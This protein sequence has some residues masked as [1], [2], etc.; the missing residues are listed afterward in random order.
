MSS[1]VSP[2]QYLDDLKAFFDDPSNQQL[3]AEM[4]ADLPDV[5]QQWLGKA[6]LL[7]GAPFNNLLVDDR[8]LPPESIR[9]FYVDQ[10]WLDALVDGVFSVGVHSSRNT[11]LVQ[12]LTGAIR[13]A[14]EAEM[15][16]VRSRLRNVPPPSEVVVGG[17]MTGILMRSAAVAGWPGLVVKAYAQPGD[18]TPLPL[19]RM[20]RLAADV[21]ICLFSGVPGRVEVDEPPEGLH[22]GVEDDDLITLRGLGYNNHPA[23]VAIS[24]LTNIEAV[25]RQDGEGQNTRVLD[26]YGLQEKLG[27][28]L[29]AQGVRPPNAPA[30]LGAADF[31]I[32]MVDA[33]EQQAFENTSPPPAADS[34]L[35]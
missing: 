19:L 24:P 12:L 28:A 9:F 11:T 33:P 29:D 27:A 25:Y 6:C 30:Q 34:N 3:I 8:M 21:L 5:M 7:Y 31:A 2:A 4:F 16:L 10:N 13:D 15:P 14:A 17:T 18:A 26:I 32:Q 23:G 22:F 20:D 1:P 35:R